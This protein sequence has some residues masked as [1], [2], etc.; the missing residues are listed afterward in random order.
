MN[1]RC[2]MII[3]L[4]SFSWLL[5]FQENHLC[6]DDTSATL[7]SHSEK[8]NQHLV[9]LGSQPSPEPESDHD[10]EMCHF[11]HCSHGLRVA[12]LSLSLTIELNSTYISIPY[13]S[14]PLAGITRPNLRPP[15]LA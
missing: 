12:V 3:F 11:G 14:M 5:S 6:S 1:V 10:K 2:Y 7:L 8:E 4:L 15:A 9:M 13:S